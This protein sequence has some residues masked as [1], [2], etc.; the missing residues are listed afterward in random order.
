[1]KLQMLCVTALLFCGSTI[2]AVAQQRPQLLPEPQ[3][4]EYGAGSIAIQG[5]VI[6][7]GPQPTAEDQFAAN[8]L[9]RGLEQKTGIRLRVSEAAAPGRSILLKRT[10]AVDALPVPGEKPGP[11][12][13]EAYQLTVSS[14]GI[15]IT[16]RS[17]AAVFYGV[18]TLLQLVEGRGDAAEFP[19]VTIHDWPSLAYRA[20]LVDV[21]SEGPMSTVEQI[22]KQIDLLARYKGNQ[23]FFYSEASI[24]LD[25]YPL[26]NPQARFTKAQ[27]RRIIAYARQRHIDV[28]P[29]VELFGHLHDLFRI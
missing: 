20:T 22:E 25:G 17:S 6:N 15:Q 5:L 29:A 24:E 11:D 18:Q 26:L 1:M 8:E 21:G 3:S 7:V 12:S 9:A 23:Y 16:G 19:V 2:S 10:G 27:V 13:R 4:V 28:V 14:H